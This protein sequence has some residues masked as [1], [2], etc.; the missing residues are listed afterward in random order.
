MSPQ[1]RMQSN[2][3]WDDINGEGFIQWVSGS[4]RRAFM[5]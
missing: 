4:T 1:A 2:L 3:V 5:G